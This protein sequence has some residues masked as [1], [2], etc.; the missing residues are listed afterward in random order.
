M[1]AAGKQL[2]RKEEEEREGQGEVRQEVLRWS[3]YD[4]PGPC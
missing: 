2:E 4:W 1:E 3:I